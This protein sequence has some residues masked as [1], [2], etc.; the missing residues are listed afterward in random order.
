[1]EFLDDFVVLVILG[2]CYCVGF[3]LKHA[4]KNETLDRFIPLIMGALGIFL[5][6]WASDW[7]ITPAIILGGL[8]SGL[9]AT[10]TNQNFKQL[11]KDSD[12]DFE[13]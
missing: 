2:I 12:E 5:N 9:A 6:V 8:A 11:T 1:M 10:G 4:V 7:A 3:I 13:N